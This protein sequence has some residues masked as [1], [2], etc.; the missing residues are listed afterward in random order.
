MSER[1]PGLANGNAFKL[2]VFASNCEG[3][4]SFTKVPER[5]DA[6][7]DHNVELA[8][9]AEAAGI[10][11]MV[12]VAR[13][14]SYGG[15]GV[16]IG[17]T[18]ETIT[19]AAGLLAETR[20]INVFGTVHVPYIHPV[21]AAK[22]MVTADQIGHGRFGLNIVCGYNQDE[23]GLFGLDPHEHDVRY[24]QGQEWWDIV[25]TLWSGAPPS[26]FEG[27]FYQLTGL[28]GL[29]LP[30]GGKNPL[31]MNAGASSAGRA[32]AIRNSDLHFDQAAKLGEM[33]ERIQETK[34]LA[35]EC[36]HD[37]QVW[38][39]LAIL[40]RPT[41]KEV[42]D[43]VRYCVDHADYDTVEYAVRLMTS[44][45]GSRSMPSAEQM[46]ADVRNAGRVPGYGATHCVYGDP[47]CVAQKLGQIHASGIDGVVFH[48]VNYLNELPY[49][50]QEVIPRLERMGIRRP[51]TPGA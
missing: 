46:R 41:Q 18:F 13:W 17:G 27:K 33:N 12:P 6:S 2:G 25:R 40:C 26:N 16:V 36:G 35:R 10:E 51:V 31:T 1:N 24:E 4:L 38:Y 22:Q 20:R 45:K 23:F 39:A 47:D 50:V 49:F 3:G 11:C 29:P 9:M 8:Q 19:W 15:P 37:I 32:F 7:W 14:K 28:D 21:L 48:F 44:A 42:D 43:Y 5:W 34:R 30:F